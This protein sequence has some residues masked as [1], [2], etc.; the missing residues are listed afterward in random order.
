[1]GFHASG[2]ASSIN[3]SPTDSMHSALIPPSEFDETSV[4]V[5]SA[6]LIVTGSAISSDF[7]VSILSASFSFVLTNSPN[8]VAIAESE[9]F[10][11]SAVNPSISLFESEIQLSAAFT[12]SIFQSSKDLL[13]TNSVH[14]AL[15][16]PSEFVE[17]LIFVPS[18][19]LIVT[20]SDISS[21][22][23]VSELDDTIQFLFTNSQTSGLLPASE[24]LKISVVI[25]SDSFSSSLFIASVF[26]VPCGVFVSDVFMV[27][28]TLRFLPY[29]TANSPG[30][31]SNDDFV[32]PVVSRSTSPL[33]AKTEGTLT[34][35]IAPNPTS[36]SR[37]NQEPVPGSNSTGLIV[38]VTV[39]SI[40]VISVVIVVLFLLK[41]KTHSTSKSD[42]DAAGYD[43]QIEGINEFM[44]EA[45]GIGHIS[46][47]GSDDLFGQNEEGF[48]TFASTS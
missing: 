34:P 22:F 32:D 43:T 28:N 10:R 11:G 42:M 24:F 30:V 4:I 8:S 35:V 46:L 1:V 14:S 36:E 48:P 41:R 15:I 29:P 7:G 38:G 5:S 45:S 25:P 40:F 12:I 37:R 26:V 16:P 27:S 18:A 47:F 20:Q 2:L 3:L 39:G 9:F 6:D 17:T 21:Y 44:D 23:K 13:L 33:I 31:S 19:S